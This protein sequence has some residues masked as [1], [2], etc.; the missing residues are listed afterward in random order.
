LRQSDVVLNLRY[1]FQHLQ[2]RTSRSV[3]T[4]LGVGLVVGVFCYLLC[5]ANG[6]RRALALSGD[7]RNLIVI[8]EGATAESNSAVFPEDVHRLAGVPQV[9]RD[10]ANQPLLS[11]EY[12]VQTDVK[13]RGDGSG[14]S[15]NV[16]VRGVDPRVVRLVEPDVEL[17]A[18]RW[19]A[20]GSDELVA[21][22]AAARQ[23]A[24]LTPGSK[25]DCGD[26]TFTIVGEFRAG[27]GVHESELWGYGPNVADAYR[28]PM[29][30]S[31]T[32]RLQSAD[33]KTVAEA[34]A[35]IAGAGIALRAL[36]EPAYYSTQAGNARVI[37]GLALSLMVIMGGGAI[38]AAMNTMHAAVTGRTREIGMLRAIGFPP[39]R[40]LLG[41]L[42]ESVGLAL[43]GGI[44][45]CA[46][47]AALIALDRGTKD[48]VGT[49]TFTS[50]AFTIA[51]TS[52]N[53]ALSLGVAAA[54]G[55]LG[56]LWPARAASRIAVVD[57]LRTV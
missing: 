38:L 14:A 52:A 39:G 18:G 10:A 55:L 35:R 36:A 27:G 9:A 20:P 46:A 4:A 11:P 28:R 40:I 24:H 23:F 32:M 29:Y 12:V 2:A 44:L 17:A 22:V 54:I 25:L 48:L 7:P 34:S 51:L 33:P 1:Q 13:R 42:A 56:G 16:I 5:L 26:R 3:L 49:A 6:L 8:A 57:A 37:E 43:L 50:V 53:V 15:A 21:G 47:C 19:F 41:I 30:S 31:A 45:G